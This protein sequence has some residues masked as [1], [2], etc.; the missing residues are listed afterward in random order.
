MRLADVLEKG[1]RDH[2]LGAAHDVSD[3]G[4]A[5]CLVEM[6][7]ASGHGARVTLPEGDAFTALFSESVAR[8]VVAV[9]ESYVDSVLAAC[10]DHDVPATRIGQVGG[11]ALEVAGQFSIGLEELRTTST[12]TLPALFA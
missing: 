6:A 9:D 11:A 2:L 3:G 1:S 8:V 7:L 4:L 12:A 10:A 5:Q